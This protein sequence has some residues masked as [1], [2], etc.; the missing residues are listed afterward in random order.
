MFAGPPSTAARCF[1]VGD[2]DQSIYAFRG[3]QVGNMA[4]FEREFRVEHVIK[5]E[6]QL[7]L[8]TATSS[9]PPTS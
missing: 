9:T 2:D 3:A 6:Q 7:P 1:A 5:L 4:D 8:A